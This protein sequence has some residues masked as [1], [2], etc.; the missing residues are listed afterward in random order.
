[1][2]QR[3][4]NMKV[5]YG[6]LARLALFVAITLLLN[7]GSRLLP[8]HWVISFMIMVVA[9]LGASVAIGLLNPRNMVHILRYGDQ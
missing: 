9:S 2:V 7:L 6:F 3:I 1:I 4:F 5:N 8:F